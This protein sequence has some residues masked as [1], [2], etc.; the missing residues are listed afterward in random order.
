M[1]K[2]IAIYC[3]TSTSLQENGLQSQRRALIE[4]CKSRGHKNYVVYEDFGISGAI[5]SRPALNEMMDRVDKGE[6]DIVI[7]YSFSRFAR[8]MKHLLEA[9]DVFKEKGTEFISISEN[10]DTT[11]AVGSLIFRILASLSEFE[12]QLI[13]ERV[14]NGMI[15]AKA[16]GK[17]IGRRKERPTDSILELRRKGFTYKQISKLLNVSEGTVCNAVRDG[18]LKNKNKKP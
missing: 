6:V 4:Y 16:K 13:S 10:I 5:K 11:S 12:R 3:R 18:L 8:S 15:N 2:I 7:V 17:Q 1:E 14:K 9:L